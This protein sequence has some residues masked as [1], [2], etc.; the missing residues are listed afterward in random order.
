MVNNCLNK[1][2][3]LL[4]TLEPMQL[5][6]QRIAQGM[7]RNDIATDLRQISIHSPYD[8]V[9]C[10]VVTE[11]GLRKFAGDGPLHTD[12]R[13]HLEYGVTIK[14]D[15]E[16]CWLTVLEAIRTHHTPVSPYVTHAVPGQPESPQTIL[17]QYYEG[18]QHT[19]L[20]MVGML[21]GDPTIVGP[22]FE[23]A[24]QANPRD[25]DVQSILAE[26]E[27][28]IKA[29]EDA[30]R[31]QPN[32]EDLRSRLA[33]RYMIVHRYAEAVEQYEWFLRLRPHTAAAWNN[34]ALCY[35]ELGQLDRSIATFERAAQEDPG[36]SRAYENLAHVY[37]QQRNYGA[38]RQALE[39]LLPFLPPLAQAGAH[40]DLARL[41]ALQDRYDL[42]LRHLD[43]A[44][45]L[46]KDAPQF[47]QELSI[48]RQRVAE[49]AATA[50]R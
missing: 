3:V 39:R 7:S 36:L 46:A 14:R 29:L 32:G 35:K 10:A 25:R 34:L 49:R 21:Q 41:C 22:A 2:A 15:W 27:G 28:E 44:I 30:V 48:K 45:S 19:L 47:L 13:P 5:D 12:D 24:R 33:Q 42:A 18:T 6:L 4:G 31:D 23:K 8:F 11:E 16:A 50:N 26:L 1:H 9:D 17:Q 38:A 20:G 40:D 37:V 43:T